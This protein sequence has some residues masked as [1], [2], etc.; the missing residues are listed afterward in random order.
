MDTLLSSFE[1]LAIV[2]LVD[3]KLSIFESIARIIVEVF[4]AQDPLSQKRAS[5]KRAWSRPLSTTPIPR[6]SSKT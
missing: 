5:D 6:M 2:D 3:A 1:R 4:R